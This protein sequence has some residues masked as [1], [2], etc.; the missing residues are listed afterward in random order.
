MVKQK[1]QDI[2]II[3]DQK[4]QELKEDLHR[5]LREDLKQDMIRIF[6]QGVEEVILPIMEDLATKDDVGKIENRLDRMEDR[7]N[8]MDRKLDV[9]TAKSFDNEAKLKNQDLRIQKVEKV[10]AVS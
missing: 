3:L 1:T 7:L 6:N 9:V 5:D 2:S 8:Q 4:F 10:V